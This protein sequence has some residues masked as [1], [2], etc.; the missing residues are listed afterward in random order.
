MT[1]STNASL[2]NSGLLSST[3]GYF[4]TIT[5]PAKGKPIK[6]R[7]QFLDKVHMGIVFGDCVA[8]G[9]HRSALLLVY[10]ATRYCCLYGMLSLSST[11]IM[12]ALELFKADAGR[13]PHSFH[14]DLD[15]KLIGGNAL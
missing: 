1:A 5:N 6:K 4:A 8:L 13:L 12:S 7:R 9:G 11:L 10:V 15:R 2:V 3:I 14:S